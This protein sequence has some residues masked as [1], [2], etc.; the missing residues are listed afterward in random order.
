[1]ENSFQNL[2]RYIEQK[3]S[4]RC[5]NYKE[6]PLKRRIRVRMRALDIKDFSEYEIYLRKNDE[7]L[8]KLVDTITINLSYFFRNLETFFFLKDYIFPELKKKKDK[9]IFW[10]AGCAQGEEPYSLAIIA[11]ESKMLENVT[12]YGTDIDN[13]VLDIAQQGKYSNIAFQ[14]TPKD[15]LKKYFRRVPDGYLIDSAVKAKVTIFNA[16]LF[17]IPP[18]GLC[19]LIVCRNVLIYLGREAQSTVLRNFYDHLSPDGYLVIG[20]VE[21]LI[22]IPEV[23]L[24]NPVSRVEHVYQKKG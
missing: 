17:A 19:D 18:F 1:M 23:N 6:K 16:D 10:S 15:L 22:G 3:T 20:K 11:A 4:F 7:E 2:I 5:Q 8:P 12:I 24:F 13:R 21:L 14:Y 9:F